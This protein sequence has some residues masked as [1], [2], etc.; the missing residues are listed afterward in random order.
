VKLHESYEAALVRFLLA[1]IQ[2]HP[3]R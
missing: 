3:G 2:N 1:R